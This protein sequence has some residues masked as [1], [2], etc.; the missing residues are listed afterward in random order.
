MEMQRWNL[1]LSLQSLCAPKQ[2]TAIRLQ[3]SVCVCVCGMMPRFLKVVWQGNMQHTHMLC[4]AFP[5]LC[6]LWYFCIFMFSLV[7]SCFILKVWAP[8]WVLFPSPPSL[9]SPV[10]RYFCVF[11]SYVP[12][13]SCGSAL[14]CLCV[15]SRVPSCVWLWSFPW[16]CG[17]YSIKLTFCWTSTFGV[18]IWTL[19][20]C[21]TQQHIHTA[22][23]LRFPPENKNTELHYRSILLWTFLLI[24]FVP[25]IFFLISSF[26][27]QA[28]KD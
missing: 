7:F 13:R 24:V 27:K 18:Y 2:H 28:K 12:L 8:L 26:A 5:C 10:S 14:C 22:F 21:H 1:C 16:P 9:Y 19:L 17:F 11:K 3:H 4:S 20:N 6:F 15:L 25:L 23:V